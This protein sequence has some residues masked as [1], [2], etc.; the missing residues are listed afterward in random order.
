VKKETQKQMPKLLY[1]RENVFSFETAS[2][3]STAGHGDP[4]RDSLV[5][6]ED[7]SCYQRLLENKGTM[8]GLP[9]IVRAQCHPISGMQDL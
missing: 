8:R 3:F 4:D 7:E 1:Y 5:Q 9:I 6:L 2:P